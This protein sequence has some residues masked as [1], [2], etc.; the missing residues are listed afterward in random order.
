MPGAYRVSTGTPYG[1][2]RRLLEDRWIERFEQ[3]DATRDKQAY[4]LT[5][6][7]RRYLQAELEMPGRT[8]SFSGDRLASEPHLPCDGRGFCNR[9]EI[10][11]V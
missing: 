2:L 8:K 5:R 9:R 11:V 7:G 6:T 10:V 4:K 3:D 1:A